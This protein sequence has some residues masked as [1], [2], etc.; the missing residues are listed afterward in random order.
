MNLFSPGALKVVGGILL[1]MALLFGLRAIKNHYI[2]VGR[3]EVQA[4]WDKD[5]ADKKAAEELAIADRNAE[6]A[7]EK[8]RQDATNK[9][10]TENYHEID[11]LR[12][13]LTSAK[14][15]RIG[16]AICGQGVTSST[17]T[18]S[19]NSGDV[20][21]TGTRVVRE[22]VDRDIRTLMIKVEEGFAA[23]RACQTF[24]EENGFTSPRK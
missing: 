19:S 5:K 8:E 15:V 7:R 10:I 18:D 6:N 1:A 23:G 22:D 17:K 14:R 21:N 16:T 3:A 11:R 20:T 9:T 13:E 24:I 4:K 12:T 2:E